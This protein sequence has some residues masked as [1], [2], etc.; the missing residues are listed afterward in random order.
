MKTGLRLCKGLCRGFTM[1]ELMTALAIGALA[2][3]VAVPGMYTMIQNNRVVALTNQLSASIN[4][5]RMEAIR[6]G[7]RVSVCPAGNTAFTACGSAAQWAQGWVVFTDLDN[8]TNI[9]NA[10]DLVK[11]NEALPIGTTVIASSN[12]ITFD[13]S[14]F[15]LNGPVTLTI[16]APGCTGRNARTLTISNSGRLSVTTVQCS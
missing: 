2:L 3:T 12:R 8:D 6:L 7:A 13:S 15:L 14:G 11:V 16:N 5:A 1:I 9:N 10:S 4:L